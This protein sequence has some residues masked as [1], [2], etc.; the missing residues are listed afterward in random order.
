MSHS[1]CVKGSLWGGAVLRSERMRACSLLALPLVFLLAVPLASAQTAPEATL[2]MSIAPG[3]VSIALGA[4]HETPFDVTLTLRGVVCTS[5]AS[6]QVPVSVKDKPSPLAGVKGTPEPAA[7]LFDVPAGSYSSNAYSKKLLGTLRVSVAESAPS[8]HEHAF[9]LTASY[10]SG[11][12]SGCQ[13]AGSMAATDAAGSHAITTGG[14]S[15]T[16]T[17][18]THQMSDGSSM[19]NK[20]TP[21]PPLMALLFVAVIVALARR[22]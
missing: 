12:P 4:S 21:F 7:L 14:S 13:G 18:A 3:P 8:N 15:A 20:N 2:G 16:G 5:A 6:V 17:P 19:N 9:E 10:A 22:R 1:T 11:V